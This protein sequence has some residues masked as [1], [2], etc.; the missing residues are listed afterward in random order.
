MYCSSL[1]FR[2]AKSA[3]DGYGQLLAKQQFQCSNLFYIL[4]YARPSEI[5][6]LKLQ[7]IVDSFNRK[8]EVKSIVLMISNLIRV[9]TFLDTHY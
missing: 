7:E 4:E 6:N 1:G 5:E 3:D 8:L 9:L 2:T